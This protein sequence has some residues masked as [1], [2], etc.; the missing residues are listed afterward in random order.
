MTEPVQETI[1]QD[2][3]DSVL[4]MMADQQTEFDRFRENVNARL[5]AV[6]RRQV[7]KSSSFLDLDFEKIWMVILCAIL[8]LVFTRV[9][10][11]T[12]AAY[13]KRGFQD[14]DFQVSEA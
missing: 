8:A 12:L 7:R 2:E 10:V 6:E 5:A 4:S 14:G 9:A 1:A 11:W 3:R 13:K